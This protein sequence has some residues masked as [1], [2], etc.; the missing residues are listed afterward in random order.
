[1]TEA[2]QATLRCIVEN[3]AKNVRFCIMCNYEA[4]YVFIIFIITDFIR[5]IEP[6]KSRCSKYFF[7][8]IDYEAMKDKITKISD[9]ENLVLEKGFIEELHYI[10]Q[11]DMRQAI[12]LLQQTSSME[13]N[14]TIKTLRECSGVIRMI[15][16]YK[17]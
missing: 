1:M 2:A 9:L 8:P 15:F 4:R 5:L 3:N 12:T 13:D 14:L 17:F 6:L 16:K 10:A 11:G 7:G